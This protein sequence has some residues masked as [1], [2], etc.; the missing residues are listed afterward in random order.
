MPVDAALAKRFKR[1]LAQ[2]QVVLFTG[3]GF[4][5]DA[6]NSDG[7]RVP[8][9][10]ELK[11]ELS[12]LAFPANPQ[13]GDDSTLADL[14]DVAV[15]KAEGAVRELFQ[16][17]LRVDAK[18][19]PSRFRGWFSM[20]WRR[21]YT[22]N[23]DNLDE[24]I[25]GAYHLP[26][27]VDSISALNH[28][29]IQSSNLLSVHLNGRLADFPN[30]TFSVRQY[31]RRLGAPDPWYEMLV[32]ELLS[33]PVLFV[34][35]A[36]DEPGLWQHLELRQQRNEGDVELRPPSYLVSPYLSRARESLLR[37]FNV[38][39]IEAT[40]A[41]FYEAVL[42]SADAEA[43]AGHAELKR[44]NLVLGAAQSLH[45]LQ[46]VLDS[47][48]IQ[49][50]HLY[51]MGRQ[52]EW[53]DI[54][55]KGD[56][57]TRGF[58]RDLAHS[59]RRKG[60]QLL[61]LT[62][63]AASGKSTTAM[64]L[65]Q[66]FHADGRRVYVY[67]TVHGSLSASQ[68]LGAVRGAKPDVLLIDDA[69][70]FGQATGR[71][72][73]DLSALPFRPLVIAV[74]RNSRLQGLAMEDELAGLDVDEH[75]VPHLVDDDIDL[76]IGALSRV[77]K[78]GRMTGMSQE[79]RRRVFREQAGRQLLVAMYYATSGENLEDKVRSECEDL[80]GASRLS[81]AMAAVATADN[82]FITQAELLLGLGALGFGGASN[83]TMNDIRRLGERQL[84]IHVDGGWQV[85]HRWIAEKSIE[86]FM[87]TG[88]LHR[89][90]LGITYALASEIDPL[91][92]PHTRERR[93]LRRWINHDRLQKQVGRVDDC[94]EIYSTLQP[95]L[96]WSHHYWLQRGSLE[97]ECG[98]LGQARSFLESAR[99]LVD[100]TDFQVENEYAYLMLKH[101]AQNP[102][103]PESR[104]QAE[105]ALQDLKLSMDSRGEKDSYPFHVF[106]S[107]GLSWARRAP[108]T[109]VEKR[110]LLFDLREWVRRGVRQHPKAA[111]L[112]RL[113]DDLEREYLGL[114]VDG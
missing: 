105:R 107:Q 4:S 24:A 85:R 56:A 42:A 88:L 100:G 14:F 44:R 95:L 51:L 11:S 76:L 82:Q 3:A 108:L 47:P 23:I 7:A 111:D 64:R 1:Q 2:G 17:R 46:D 33:N 52:P 80:Q 103:S 79:Q 27:A 40:E 114:A 15:N 49:D 16:A 112:V 81:Y 74:M 89:A 75:A 22:L 94:R 21:H 28:A 83:Q 97:V 35:T 39:W 6:V 32:T 58:E 55:P 98:D 93:L 101:A 20:P 29:P 53:A 5:Y 110:D 104:A 34:G 48:G 92:S 69:D 54:G 13:V 37:R 109:A 102:N 87:D 43:E 68:V 30:V 73:R 60:L 66:G 62:G 65:A 84:L 50:R 77:G 90:V 71:L 31:G 12:R 45:R 59:A 72:L 26:R 41:E 67:D 63:T 18:A 78:L 38:S 86:F 113:A 10:K 61:L 57:V 25:A 19:S 9:V 8:Q 99:S 36:L 91:G 70:I 96:G 106:G